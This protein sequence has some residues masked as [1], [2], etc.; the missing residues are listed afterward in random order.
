MGVTLTIKSGNDGEESVDFARILNL[1]YVNWAKRHGFATTGS[2]SRLNSTA[3]EWSLVFSD[4]EP[5]RLGQE[6][7]THRLCRISPF[8]SQGRRW[9]SWASVN[10]AGITEH[11]EGPIRSYVMS[12]YKQ[13]KDE[14]KNY[15][16]ANIDDVLAG[17]VEL[18]AMIAAPQNMLALE[19]TGFHVERRTLTKE[20]ADHA[21]TLIPT[22]E[23]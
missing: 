12:P 18:D 5:F 15:T 2:Y 14:R 21:L 22:I 19:N 13:A 4:I 16:T 10:V 3:H 7:G 1:M 23:S 8:D 11:P 17:G 9:T 6:H 20:E